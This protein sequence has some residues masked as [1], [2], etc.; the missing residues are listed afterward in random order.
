[1]PRRARVAV[2]AAL[3]LA[4]SPCRGAD[5]PPV[6]TPPTMMR[7]P[8]ASRDAIAFVAHAALFTV[9]LAGGTARRVFDDGDGVLAPHFSPDGRTIAFTAHHRGGFDVFVVPASGGPAFQLTHDAPAVAGENFVL[10]WTPDGRRVLFLSKRRSPTFRID[11]AFAVP[12]TGGLAEPLPLDR[13][14]LLSFAPDGH[15]VAF[16]SVFRDLDTR[17]RYLGGEAATVGIDD[18][19]TGRFRRLTHWRGTDTAPMWFGRT[20]YFLSDRGRDFRANLWA[21]DLDRRRVRQVT[22]FTDLDVEFPSLG[23]RTITFSQGGAL[24]ALDLPSERLRRV[25]VAV[26]DDGQHTAAATRSVGFLARDE[27]ALGGIDWALAP[28]GRSVVIAAGGDLFRLG[29]D[30]QATDLTATPGIDEDHPSFSPDGGRIAYETERGGAQQVAIRTEPGGPERIVTRFAAGERFEPVWSPTGGALVLADADGTLWLVPLDGRGGAS[31]V[32]RDPAGAIRDAAFSP[33]GRWLAWSATRPNGTRAI[34]L[35][36]LASGRETVLGTPMQSDRSPVFSPDGLLLLFVTQSNALPVMSDRDDG[37]GFVAVCSDAIAAATLRREDPA[38]SSPAF[39][40]AARGG[41]FRI[42]LDGLRA[43]AVALPIAP[44]EIVSL[45]IRGSTVFYGTAPVATLDGALPGATGAL[46]AFD[47]GGGGGRTVATDVS[48]ALVSADGSRIG[49]RRDG[50]WHLA[51]SGAGTDGGDE[52][53]PDT[54]SRRETTLDTASLRAPVDPRQEWAE[55][56]DR[57]WRL[58]RDLFFSSALNGDDW[59]AVHDHYRSL[60]GLVGSDDDMQFLLGALQGELASSHARVVPPPASGAT[61]PLLALLGAD[62]RLDPVSGR[63]R[64]ARVLAGDATVA[65]TR[66]PLA[67]PGLE[68]RAGD[69]ILA[70]DGQDLRPPSDPDQLLSGRR[71]SVTLTLAHPDGPPYRLTVQ[72]LADEAPLRQFDWVARTRARVDRLS[73]GRV[74]YV[75]LEDFAARGA[76]DFIRQYGP[77]S[78]KDGLIIDIR[79]NRGGFTSQAVLDV[80]RRA[81]AGVFVNRARHAEPL[82]SLTA[83]PVL[84]TLINGGTASDGDQFAY[85]VRQFG[86][87]P[88]VGTRTWGG[89][90]GIDAPWPLMNGTGLLIPKD[91]LAADGHWIIENAGVAPDVEVEDRPD[92][93]TPDRDAPLERAVAVALARL[94][95]DRRPPVR[96]PAPLPA[97]PPAG[98]V[99]GAA[100]GRG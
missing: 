48:S 49:F 51:S 22:R 21:D 56:F 90:Q 19:A 38:P 52:A 14:G 13:T 67:A 72:P 91:S 64:I 79:D 83:P 1:M 57:A 18:L 62:L 15:T 92:A 45:A 54:A 66:S 80:L 71:S 61:G 10:G 44:A 2:L 82:P 41:P 12:V 25:A 23:G 55:M 81:R 78:G 53:T 94:R 28:D 58:D 96:I 88:L 20:I 47:L 77:Q 59:Q 46:H 85:Y 63:Y 43:R 26:P 84:V 97:Y 9:P 74:G 30:G 3:A 75:Y 60:V 4:S 32:A 100:F 31:R 5:A 40:D 89:V 17:K 69:T 86:L 93:A 42:D 99:P 98:E 87:G 95:T 27:D 76:A 73:F 35:R 39:R 65:E 11:R 33:D 50:H 68:V 37:A 34:H 29:A 6:A 16:A 70:I 8:N 24:W 7:F 36:A